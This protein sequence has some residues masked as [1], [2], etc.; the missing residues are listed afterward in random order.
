MRKTEANVL[1][2]ASCLI[3]ATS[4]LATE[5]THN[6]F[7]ELPQA[8]DVARADASEHDLGDSGFLELTDPIDHVLRRAGHGSGTQVPDSSLDQPLVLGQVIKG[9]KPSDKP[10]EGKK[11]D[12]MM[13]VAWIKS[14]TGKAGKK[15][16]VFNTTMGASQDLQS[17]GLRRLLVNACYWSVGLAAR[18]PE[19]AKV[20]LVGDYEPTR[21]GF[22][23]FRKGV[24]PADYRM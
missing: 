1:R 17:E 8:I 6:L 12:P 3:Q 19:K 18:I 11:N 20:D 9:M 24:R 5:R 7:F 13:P 23:G 15:A 14:Y 21:F 16:R 22:G 10:L 2:A 4:F